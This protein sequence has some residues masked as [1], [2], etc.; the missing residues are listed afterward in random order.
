MGKDQTKYQHRYAGPI[1]F[2][3]LEE[4]EPA[5]QPVMP[6]PAHTDDAGSGLVYMSF[7][8]GSSGNCSY[9]GTAGEGILIDAA[10]DPEQVF[11]RLRH[12]GIRPD[13]VKGII[14]THDHQDHVRYVYTVVRRY[15]KNARIY[16]T[17]RV[18]NGLL[19]RHNISRR[20]KEYHIPIW[21]ETPF[22][23]SEFQITAFET[24]HDGTENMGFSITA[25]SG[26]IFV[27]ATDMGEI[28]P[29]AEHYMQQAHYL[30]IESNYD[31]EMLDNGHYPEYL[32]SRVRGPK[33]HL[34]NEVAAAFVHDHYHKNLK[35]V[36]LCHLSNDN[37]TPDKAREAM[38]NALK[39]L[40]LTV[41]D[42][43]NAVDQ[44]NRDVQLYAL[45]RYECS[46]CFML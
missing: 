1:L 4:Q 36:F 20:V 44:R 21:M 45:P 8:S 7:G 22:K 28:T 40:N 17:M 15:N 31:R 37:N 12:N 32:K 16:C 11:D 5:T 41:G 18:M 42:G 39:S 34:D 26:N 6:V 2:D 46:P 30:M 33:G 14:L 13:A 35:W 10:V 24:S 25:P 9:L 3:D 23:L 19:R 38:S 43:S 27:V 29:R